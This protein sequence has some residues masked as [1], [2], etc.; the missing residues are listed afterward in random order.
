MPSHEMNL[1]YRI[2]AWRFLELR[3][4]RDEQMRPPMRCRTETD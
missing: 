1:L 3:P 4:R 2:Q